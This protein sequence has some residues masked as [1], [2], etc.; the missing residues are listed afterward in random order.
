MMLARWG[1]HP[2]IGKMDSLSIYKSIRKS[3]QGYGLGN[4]YPIRIFNTYL[5]KR[6]KQDRCE[7]HGH[8]MFLDKND[9][10]SLSVEENY[11]PVETNYAIQNIKKGDIV[12]DLGAFI[13]YYTL[14]FARIVGPEGKVYAFEPNPENFAILK[15]NVEYNGYKNVVLINKAVSNKN[16]KLQFFLSKLN[17]GAGSLK[18]MYDKE[19]GSEN[20]T[21]TIEI[22]S[23]KL[24][25][26]FKTGKINFIKMD[27]EGAEYLALLG[28]QN[29]IRRSPNIKMMVEYQPLTL[30]ASGVQPHKLISL[31]DELGF[32][33][34]NSQD[35]DIG[36][37]NIDKGW[38][39]LFCERNG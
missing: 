8:T 38:T 4:F 18:V 39:N 24:D 35:K 25:D 10:Q 19:L 34:H 5:M 14:V 21:K 7:V 27:I 16:G 22:E 3:L 28:M 36:S 20:E 33:I 15:R 9:A 32:K 13:G 1:A 29:M 2:R 26:Y 30:S 12:L 37:Y 6:L 31:I 11:E 17:E 23:V